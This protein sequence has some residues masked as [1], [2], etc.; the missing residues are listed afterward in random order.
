VAQISWLVVSV[1]TRASHS[2]PITQIEI[3]TA[4]FAVLAMATY[5]V[6][7]YKPKDIGRPIMIDSHSSTLLHECR[8]HK[9][10]GESFL[11]RLIS[12]SK[13]SIP[14]LRSDYNRIRNDYLQSKV[15]VNSNTLWYSLGVSTAIFGGIHCLAVLEAFPTNTERI[16]WLAASVSSA[17]LPLVSFILNYVLLQA[18]E[19]T[20]KVIELKLEQM[21]CTRTNRFS[22]RLLLGLPGRSVVRYG[23][24]DVIV[25]GSHTLDEVNLIDHHRSFTK[26]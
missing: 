13:Q 12:P 18:V 20:R 21:N 17:T 16:I 11:K 26:G 1:I 14:I 7:W 19:R 6:S 24:L 23:K 15:S 3:C 10:M 8:A 25:D 2:L 5:L 22:Y 9:Y 4:A